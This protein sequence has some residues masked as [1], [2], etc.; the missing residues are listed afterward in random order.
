MNS[1]PQHDSWAPPPPRWPV[2]PATVPGLPSEA[3]SPPALPSR[4]GGRGRLLLAALLCAVLAL[5]FGAV[6]A[7]QYRAARAPQAVVQRYFAALAAGDA[8][9]AL[10]LASDPQQGDYLTSAVLRQ[11]L[12]VAAISDVVVRSTVVD[13]NTATSQ[14]GYRLAFHSSHASTE[15]G[16][17]VAAGNQV[18]DA[19]ELVKVGSSWR[20]RRAAV[21]LVLSAVA[22]SQNRLTFAGRPLPAGQLLVFPGALPLAT[23]NPAVQPTGQPLI[24]LVDDGKHADVSVAITAAAERSLTQALTRALAGCLSGTSKDLNCPQPDVSRPIPGSLRG[25]QASAEPPNFDLS[26]SDGQI[27]LT[28]RVTVNGSWQVWDFNNQSIKRSGQA[29]LSVRAAASI[30]DLGSIYWNAG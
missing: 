7:G 30:T 24:R 22:A 14:V 8:P 27:E 9:T 25:N 23:D 11:Q 4:P 29:K 5:L 19:V 17:G 3:P 1:V 15:A 16:S 18:D 10:A 28:D 12:A 26:T 20:L 2:P 21:N 6:A 13:G